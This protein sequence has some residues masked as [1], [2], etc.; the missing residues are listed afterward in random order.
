MAGR[1]R[2]FD[3]DVAI[4]AALTLFIEKGYEGASF[5]D[6]TKAMGIS[7][8]SFYAAFG[9]KEGLFRHA[10][11]RYLILAR[12]A[13]RESMAQPTARDAVSHLLSGFVDAVTSRP[14]ARGCLLIQ[15]ALVASD[16]SAHIRDYLRQEREATTA[17]L[18]SRF[19]R[20][21][22]AGDKTVSG[23][24]EALARLTSIMIAGIATQAASGI[25]KE[26]LVT[27]VESFMK[28]FD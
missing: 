2:Q 19:Q 25:S 6:L 26:E 28:L 14:T 24:P 5:A 21:V 15:G 1:P 8:P 11:D 18:L 3:I 22:T 16:G 27:A 10:V 20:A 7:P 23:E 13:I 4:D 17:A 9:S 12:T